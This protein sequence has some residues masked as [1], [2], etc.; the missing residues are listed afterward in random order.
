MDSYTWYQELIKPAWAPPSWLFGPVWSILYILI[1]ISFG[2]VVYLHFKKRIP[3]RVLIP[4]L[5]N[6]FF[7]IIFTPIQF[8][9]KSNVLAAVDVALVLFTLIWAMKAIYPYKKWVTYIQIPY[10]IWVA[11]ATVLQWTVTYLNF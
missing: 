9:L 4:F 1:T 2:F 11:F 7:N 6:L 3:N 10:V 8:W 5:L